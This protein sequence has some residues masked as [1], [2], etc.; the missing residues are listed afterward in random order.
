M[1]RF[2]SKR[3][4]FLVFLAAMSGILLLLFASLN[5]PFT[6]RFATKKVNQILGH[7]G[8]PIQIDA[9]KKILPPSVKLDGVTING[10]NG[11]TIIRVGELDVNCRLISLLRKK[12]V[13]R[14]VILD[15][16]A[17][18]LLMN[19]SSR[20]LNIAETFQPVPT[21]EEEKAEKE[22]A[23]WIISIRHGDLSGIRFLMSDSIN[24]LHISQDISG[25]ELKDFR[26]S[27]LGSEI[28]CQS[29]DLL[30][31]DGWLSLTPRRVPAK[32]KTGAP[33]NISLHDL[34]LNEIYF[35]FHKPADSLKLKSKIG[36]ARIRAKKMDLRSR[37]VDIR[38]LS[39]AECST[40]LQ[41]GED[42]ATAINT[43]SYEEIDL[44][45]KDF[46]LDKDEFGMKVKKMNV[47]LSN[48]FSLTKLKGE[49]HSEP[50]LSELEMDIETGNSRINMKGTL[51]KS[52][53][54][55][56][57]SPEEIQNASLDFEQLHLSPNDISCFI[58]DLQNLAYYSSLLSSPVDIKGRL[59]VDDSQFILSEL[60]L[61]Q[62]GNFLVTA[63]GALGNPFRF[64]AS[65]ADLDVII[66]EIDHTW[67]ERLVKES[68]IA[69]SIPE[70]AELKLQAYISDSLY[71]PSIILALTSNSGDVNLDASL[72]FQNEN[73][74]LKY[75][76]DRLSLS[77]LLNVP[78]LG[79]I[80]GRGQVTGQAFSPK[81]MNARFTIQFDTIG[82]NDYDYKNVSLAGEFLPDILSL[83][84]VTGDSAF[85]SDLG[86]VLNLADSAIGINLE[87]QLFA[88]LNELN[89]YEDTLVVE[90]GMKAAV[91][92]KQGSMESEIT[93][94]GINL[95]SPHENALIRQ[96][97]ACFNSDSVMTLLRA[98]S[99]FFKVDLQV[100]M[101]SDELDSLGV[102]YK[103]YFASF[104]DPTHMTSE[105]RLSALS[106]ISAQASISPHNAIEMFLK[107]TALQFTNLDLSIENQSEQNSLKV[108]IYGSEIK[109][110]MAEIQSLQAVIIDSAGLINIH[111]AADRASLFS[112][113]KHSWQLTGEY[114]DW[115][116]QSSVLINDSLDQSVYNIGIEGE[117]DSS[118]LVLRIPEQQFLLNRNQ[119]ELEASEILSIDLP[120]KASKS[121]L[122]MRL[123]SSIISFTAG[124]E[125]GAYNYNL[126]M[127]QLRYS[128]LIRSDL[129]PGSPDGIITGSVNFT[130]I[131]ESEDI[132]KTALQLKHLKYSGQEFDDIALDGTMILGLSDDYSIDLRASIDSSKLELSADKISM[133][134]RSIEARYSHFPLKSIQP[135]T[136][137][138]ISELHGSISGNLFASSQNDGTQYGGEVQFEDAG[139]KVNILNSVFRIPNQRILLDQ[140]KLHFDKFTILDT[141][142]KKLQ[143]DGTINFKKDNQPRADLLITSEKLQVMSRDME[144]TAPFS[145]NVFIDTRFSIK[146]PLTNPVVDGK[147][148]LARGTEVYY[149]LLEDLSISESEKIVS[150]VNHSAESG[151]IITPIINQQGTFTNS[152]IETIVRIDPSTL[153]NFSL[154][155]RAYDINL[156]I[157]GG[158]SV[159]YNILNKN[160][161]S[162][163]GRYEIREGEAELKLTGWPN[164]SF[165]ISEGGYVRWDGRIDN[166]E[167]KLEAANK[168]VSSYINPVD[169]KR[170]EVDFNVIL[171]ISEYLSDMEVLFTISTPDQYLMSIINT[172]SPEEQTRQAISVL[173]FET[174]D[175][176][177][178]SSSSDYMTQ[179]VNQIL[180]SQLNQLTKANIKG[181]DVSFG[182]DSYSDPTLEEGNETRTNL[183]YEVSKSLLKNR[184]TIEFSGRLKDVNQQPGASDLSLNNLTFEY[185][186]D[187]A[188]TKYL[189]VYNEQSF[190]DVFEGEVIKT[191]VG[192]S[193]RKKYKSVR[194]IWKRKK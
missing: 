1:K 73:F 43:S 132:I 127:E 45:I 76:L 185:Q 59:D 51:E 112:G 103:N 10:I 18:E 149:Q 9:I 182:L 191:G 99:D 11:D 19:Y 60:T 131:A 107:D 31:A 111:M 167:L 140:S 117:V 180:S 100:L 21:S 130:K 94:N 8:L 152:S 64:S 95:S 178:I 13:I 113:P 105:N 171:Q 106:E 62:N 7:S 161:V 30:N 175:L 87:G 170:R 146:G 70:L 160:Q 82:F 41:T 121:S 88:K 61:T 40:I 22:K 29:I 74:D 47:D 151:E 33:R 14:D 126:D 89:L 54:K 39:L 165:T 23:D 179:Q 3:K 186:I 78:M 44:D 92:I 155:K 162:L 68:G 42:L 156:N 85:K 27:I 53:F 136:E 65:T 24:G 91:N 120:T 96:I 17:V 114:A 138:H 135:F 97:S 184:A 25:L 137:E 141:L 35:T 20:N 55:F 38:K 143:V 69:D 58:P 145:G 46:K 192:I 90:T 110:E 174:I 84:M 119:W 190:D 48:G 116:M 86:I 176:P 36:T 49:I 168:V 26:I 193:H 2:R 81:A 83:D 52:L 177:G 189:K 164:K 5:L 134:K 104:L 15:Q 28:V 56:I 181:F 194:D 32:K 93:A 72:D 129:I 187:S 154:S 102:G 150:F 115:N 79:S 98:E 75:S 163:T 139:L 133:G 147:I 128:S 37:I 157:R 125:N 80:S 122:K 66:S 16:A 118:Q 6:Q 169:G 108:H 158:G 101:P 77:K 142:N 57:A 71:S 148:N 4:L 173:L 67:I 172:M 144:S 183:S 159:K 109:Y 124:E 34:D 63:D 153:I 123:D 50:Q 12:V 188:A 166:P